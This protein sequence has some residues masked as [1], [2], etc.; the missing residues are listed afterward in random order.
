M[1]LNITMLNGTSHSLMVQP[2]D[3]VGSL[4][5]TIHTKFGLVS[6]TQR[7]IYD[8]GQR[9]SLDDDSRSLSSYG[10]QSGSRLSLLVTQPTTIQVFLR[11]EKGQ[12]RTYDIGPDMTV[13]DFKNKVQRDEGVPVN[14]QRLIHEGR[15]MMT[16]RLSDYGVKA[17]STVYLTLRLRGG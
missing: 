16:G 9:T 12:T 3:T 2:H 14:Q 6:Q 1:E 8:N 15:E 11:N 7:L 4:K 13:N 5:T 17:L 10:L